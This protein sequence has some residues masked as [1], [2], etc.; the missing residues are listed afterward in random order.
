[1]GCKRSGVGPW[2]LIGVISL[3]ATGARADTIVGSKHDLSTSTTPQVCV[4]CHTPH[5]ANTAVAAPLWNRVASGQTFTMYS[6]PTMDSAAAGQPRSR[7]LV[8]LGCHD[9]VNAYGTYLGNSASTKHDL[10]NAPGSGGVPDTSSYPKCARCHGAM[11][12]LPDPFP[13]GVDLTNDHPISIRYPTAAED[14]AF[15]VPPDANEGWGPGDLRLYGGW[16]ECPTCH[17][18]HDPSRPAFLRKSNAG[19]ALCKTCHVK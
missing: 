11:Y 10:L 13:I 17:E 16:I 5:L 6:S 19:S 3:L 12:G 9:N 4:F 7:S 18:P 2:A 15:R 8:C 14:P 1:M